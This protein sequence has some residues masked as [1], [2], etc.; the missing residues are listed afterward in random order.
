[1][2]TVPFYCCWVYWYAKDTAKLDS[3]SKKPRSD[4]LPSM[5]LVQRQHKGVEE[6]NPETLIWQMCHK[7]E[8]GQKFHVAQDKCS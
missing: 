8:M 1:M 5:A 6:G 7:G 3:H 2:N 4:P